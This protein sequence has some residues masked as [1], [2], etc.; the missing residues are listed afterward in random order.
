M[1]A[2]PALRDDW[3]NHV[4]AYFRYD[5]TGV[6]PELRSR[7]SEQAVRADGHDELVNEALLEKALRAVRCPVVL[8]RAPR[9][10]M[11]E[12]PGIQPPKLV[13][14]WRAELPQLDDELVEGTNHYTIAFGPHGAARVAARIA[15]PG[16]SA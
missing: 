3:N 8:L 1:R 6:E 5:L 15:E 16:R 11:N 2:H 12:P 14:R 7:V 4:E 10:L 13:A 9:G